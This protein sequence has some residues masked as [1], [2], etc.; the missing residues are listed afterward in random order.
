M[1][2][3]HHRR[4]SLL[5][6]VLLVIGVGTAVPLVGFVSAEAVGV[7]AAYENN[8]SLSAAE[9]TKGQ[10]V[11]I[12][13]HVSG[14]VS[15]YR[16]AYY[17]KKASSE[18]WTTVKGFSTAS[19]VKFT[20]AAAVA[21]DIKVVAKDA[22]NNVTETLRT[23]KVSPALVNNSKVSKTAVTLGS[24]VTLKGS[25]KG[26]SGSYTYAYYWKRASASS[27]V[28]L[29]GYSNTASADFKPGAAVDY[30]LMIKVKDS[31]GMIEKS[32]FALKVY[33]KLVNR[34]SATPAEIEK[35]E[36]VKLVGAAKG[37]AGDYRYSYSYK[38]S[39]DTSWRLLQSYSETDQITCQIDAV[40]AV[41]F[42]IKVKDSLGTVSSK[43]ITVKVFEGGVNAQIDEVLAG[44]ITPEMS[45]FDKV[46]AIHDWLLNNVQYDESAYSAGG[47]PE[48]SY[49]VEG[50]LE[51]GLAVCDG[52]AK[53]F[54]LMAERAG[55]EAIRV[56]GQAMSPYGSLESHAWNQ[57]KVDGQWYNMDVTWDD[58]V[59]SEDYGDNRCYT[60]F[61]VPD[62]MIAGTHQASSDKK[63]CTAPQPVEKLLP[64]LLAEE[65]QNNQ[66]FVYC[67][68]EEAFK[69]AVSHIDGDTTQTTTIVFCTDMSVSDA[70]KL[71]QQNRPSTTVG[72]R[73]GMDGKEW[74]LSGYLYVTVTIIVSA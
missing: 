46:K 31:H 13:S 26:G 41:Q 56:T 70:F 1:K 55:L 47:A 74:K 18:K 7:T 53:T 29:K 40:G 14:G 22:Q 8:V 11:T 51:T 42:L 23:L 49:T 44:I 58:P 71:V 60:Y 64:L 72:Y 38:R 30:D 68:N 39:S 16:Y 4:I 66:P 59:V 24:T 45:E 6:A 20:P 27:W 67:E 3:Q 17:A 21:Y 48:T 9:I 61:M 52:Y 32:T 69:S 35:G 5:L 36:Q 15:P 50:L 54:Q 73:M 28:T 62:S 25:A 33:P 34:S 65:E 63:T 12:S 10:S 37:G 43:T 57:V 19:S 2:M